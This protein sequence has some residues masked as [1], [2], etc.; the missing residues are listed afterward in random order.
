M[1]RKPPLQIIGW[2]ELIGLPVLG[3][4]AIKA[5]VDTGARSSALHAYGLRIE[6]REGEAL[7]A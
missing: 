6:R 3:V 7:E 1:S 4:P 5:K 2:R